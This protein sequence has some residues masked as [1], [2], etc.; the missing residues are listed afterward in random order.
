MIARMRFEPKKRVAQ[1]F[2]RWLCIAAAMIGTASGLAGEPDEFFGKTFGELDLELQAAKKQGKTGV[3]IAFELDDC[4]ICIRMREKV[5]VRPEVR[6]YYHRNFL[7]FP[8]DVV[9]DIPLRDFEGRATTEK[10]FATAH[11]VRGT[12]TFLFFD[13]SGRAVARHVGG[14]RDAK[15][16]L[17][18]GRFVVEGHYRS[19]SFKEF[20]KAKR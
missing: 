12:P 3:L 8:V 19:Q 9:G 16:F 10:Q 1:V 4:E 2:G 7:V 13:T 20:Q 18:L 6:E 14:T 11:R 17:E 15:E 5:F